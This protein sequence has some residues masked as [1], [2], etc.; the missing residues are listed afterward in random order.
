MLVDSGSSNTFI[1][2]QLVARLTG[3]S[4]LGQPLSVKVANDISMHCQFQF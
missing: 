4:R 1:S 3:V 2:S